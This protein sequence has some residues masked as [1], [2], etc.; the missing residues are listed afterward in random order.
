MAIYEKQDWINKETVVSAERMNH[1]ED[2]IYDASISGSGKTGDTL[3]IGTMIPYGGMVVPTNWLRCDGRAISRTEYADLFNII[4]VSYGEGNGTTTF[5]LPDK[6]GRVSV[7]YDSDNDK[8]ISIG[9]H[10]GE[11]THTLTIDEIPAHQHKIIAGIQLSNLTSG[12]TGTYI[13]VGDTY[14]NRIGG[15]Q[16]HNNIQPTEVDNWIIKVSQSAG[17]V[18]TV[19]NTETS[20]A[21]DTYSCDYINEIKGEILH[22]N[23]IGEAGSFELTKSAEGYEI[24]EVFYGSDNVFQS[25]RFNYVADRKFTTTNIHCNESGFMYI[26]NSTWQINGKQIT[27]TGIRNNFISNEN[28]VHSYGSNAYI[29]IYKVIGYK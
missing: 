1:I 27:I 25:T 23:P 18:S 7:G 20:S 5:N 10:L 3:P 17:V 26:Y 21:T 22:I 12:G 9:T 28:E 16:P 4:G 6:R 8:F 11:E 2:G 29:K 24:I 19:A 14:T 15:S 13:G